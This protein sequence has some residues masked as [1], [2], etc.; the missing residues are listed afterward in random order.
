M[1]AAVLAVDGGNSKTD[2]AL[3]AA[4]GQLLAA[5]RGPT[6]S[7]Q[8]LGMEAGGNRLERLVRLASERAGLGPENDRPRVGVYCLAGA[9]FPS[10]V[11]LLRR[12]LA[13]HGLSADD[14]VLNDTFAAL[15]AGTENGWGIVLICGQGINGA[16]VAP[17]GRTYRFA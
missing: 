12:E 4:D 10:D 17:N 15:R 3:V 7:H 16:G 13:T 11:H 5:V 6:V 9:D 1:S 8:V 14:L 2:V